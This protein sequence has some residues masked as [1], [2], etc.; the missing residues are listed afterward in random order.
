MQDVIHLEG[1]K[2]EG[3]VRFGAADSAPLIQRRRFGAGQF[4]ADTWHDTGGKL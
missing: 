4:G 2:R 3:R 1:R